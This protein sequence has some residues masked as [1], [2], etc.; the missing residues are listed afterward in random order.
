MPSQLLDSRHFESV[1]AP[2]RDRRVGVVRMYGNVGD[3]LIDWATE[4]L[5]DQFGIVYGTLNW[6]AGGDDIDLVLLDVDTVAFAGG[7]NLGTTYG[8]CT[9]LR[10]RYHDCGKSLVVMPQSITDQG[11]DLSVYDRI[12]LREQSSLDACPGGILAPDL[13]LGFN[14]PQIEVERDIPLGVFVRE[15]D[16]NAIGPL[17]QSLGDPIKLCD[18]VTEYLALAGRCETIYTDRLHFAI[19]GLIM[20]SKVFLLPGSYFKNRAV[21]DTWLADLGCQW[22]DSAADIPAFDVDQVDRLFPSLAGP[23]AR[24]IPWQAVPELADGIAADGAAGALLDS[25]SGELVALQDDAAAIV[26]LMDGRQSLEDITRLLGEREQAPLVDCARDVQAIARL[27]RDNGRLHVDGAG[28]DGARVHDARAHAAHIDD[29]AVQPSRM[30]FSP[31]RG[32]YLELHVDSPVSWGKRQRLQATLRLNGEQARVLWFEGDS[33]DP[34]FFSPMA[35]AFVLSSLQ[36]AMRLGVPLVVSGAPVS[37]GLLRNLH[38]FQLVFD[39]WYPSLSRID[40]S[41]SEQ[42]A[43]DGGRPGI[44]AFS[45]GVDSSF[46]ILRQ[47]NDPPVQWDYALGAALFV[48]GFDVYVSSAASFNRVLSRARQ[49]LEDQPLDLLAVNTNLREINT[50]WLR[51]HGLGVAATLSLFNH[52]FGSGLIASTIPYRMLYPF[53]SNAITDRLMGSDGFSIIHDGAE[54]DRLAK[55]RYLAGFPDATRHLRF[56]FVNPDSHENCGR[57]DK[58]IT[59][60][61]LMTVAGI[62]LSCFRDPPGREDYRTVLESFTGRLLPRHLEY[63]ELLSAWEA[64]EQTTDRPEWHGDLGNLMATLRD[65]FGFRQDPGPPSDTG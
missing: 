35:D 2:F 32:K 57:C 27:L 3:R 62:P 63:H 16:E 44:C 5:L 31:A 52:R 40:I 9:E 50:E 7:G 58:C 6:M 8:Y 48:R 53:G 12:Y 49:L 1:F 19:S 22:C 38:E 64:L 20:G 25:E 39:A 15:D 61:I 55:L 17:E 24:L 65:R 36:P 42:A 56:C 51:C 23:A 26:E 14:P 33:D 43:D 11:E 13:A 54:M 21:F 37:S 18:S 28:V 46:S 30:S 60:A 47:L 45:G 4:Q 34:E 59:T 10:R 29:T 41:A